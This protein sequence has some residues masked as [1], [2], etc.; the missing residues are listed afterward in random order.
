MRAWSVRGAVTM[1]RNIAAELTKYTPDD[2]RYFDLVRL[3]CLVTSTMASLATKLRLTPQSSRD[4][5]HVKL[6]STLPKPW[7]I[8]DIPKRPD[9]PPRSWDWSSE[10]EPPEEPRPA[11]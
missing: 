11:A 2:D 1:E 5:R 4:S 10:T 3:R 8:S 9:T 7:E 6:V